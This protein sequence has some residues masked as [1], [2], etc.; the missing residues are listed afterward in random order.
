VADGL[1]YDLGHD[2]FLVAARVA[3]VAERLVRACDRYHQDH[4]YAFGMTPSLVADLVA[5][6]VDC[7]RALL[8]AL[9]DRRL[10]VR[11]GRIARADF[12]VALSQ[13][14]QALYRAVAQ[15]IDEGG[16]NPPAHGNLKSAFQAGEA[17]LKLIE[18]LL[19]EEG[20][21]VRIGANFMQAAAHGRSRDTLR[22]L[23]VE[24]GRVELADFRAA[25][26]VGR[27][28]AVALLEGFDAEGL[29]RREGNARVAAHTAPR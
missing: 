3:E 13:K 17:D 20:L 16:V 21:A 11:H 25:T 18:H 5:V 12:A 23:L 1:V 26:G 2:T 24:H 7:V 4:P 15:A 27:N 10:A 19:V 9:A 14:Q 29:T 22:S 6:P 28:L 8:R